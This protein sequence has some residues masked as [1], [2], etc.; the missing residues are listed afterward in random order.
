MLHTTCMSD[1][2]DIKY[3]GPVA[4]KR[5]WDPDREKFESIEDSWFVFLQKMVDKFKL[6]GNVPH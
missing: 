1:D 2:Q 4:G 5:L 6:M 3:E